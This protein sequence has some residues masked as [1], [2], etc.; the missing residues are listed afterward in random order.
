MVAMKNMRRTAAER[1]TETKALGMPGDGAER[2][3]VP[4]EHDDV[5]VRLEHHHIQKLFG[6][7]AGPLPHGTKVEFGGHGEVGESGTREGYGDAEPRHHMTIRLRRAG[8]EPQETASDRRDDLRADVEKASAA[9]DRGG[10]KTA[11]EGGR[12]DRQIPEKKD[13]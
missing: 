13:G 8:V 9:A 4:P 11:S 1:D 7:A 6:D 5:E 10:R 3:G 2:K 12:A